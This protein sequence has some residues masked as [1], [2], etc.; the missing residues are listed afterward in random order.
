MGKYKDN[1]WLGLES[2]QEDQIIFGR[3]KEIEEMSQCILNYNETLLFGK[4]G[5]GKSSIINAGILPVARAHDYIP[6]VVRLDHSNKH[7][8][9]KQINDQICKYTTICNCSTGKDI[10]E[11]L[12][13]E[14]FHTREFKGTTNAKSKSKLLIVFDQFEEIFT[15][16]GNAATKIQFFKEIGDVLNDVMPKSLTEDYN[17][18]KKDNT[19][20]KTE[21]VVQVTGFA[22]MTDLFSCI[23]EQVKSE[24]NQYI[25]DNDIHF[26]FTLREDFLSEFEYYT[27]R[28][29]SLKQHRYGLRPINEEQAAEIIM[30]PRPELVDEGV[31]RLII[32]TVTNRTDF[33]LGDEPE[34]DV[35]AAVLSLFLS[36]IYD[37]REN[38]HDSITFE[39]VKTF[40]RNII[41]D[42]YEESIADLTPDQI[43]FLE[44]ELLTGE[45]RRD[46]LS[47]SDL[48][49]GGFSET[50]LRHLIDDKKILRLFS[51]GGD[52]RIEFIHD[53]LCPIIKERKEQRKKQLESE[54]ERIYYQK[55]I[56]RQ[57]YLYMSLLLILS[58]AIAYI[59]AITIKSVNRDVAVNVNIKESNNIK[60]DAYWRVG[61]IVV[62]NS[63]TLCNDTLDKVKNSSTFFVPRSKRYTDMEYIV[64]PIIGNIKASSSF[65][66]IAD[67]TNILIKVEPNTKE[68][69]LY[70]KLR[71]S[72]GSI[73]P[74]IGAIVIWGSQVTKTSK[75]GDFSFNEPSDYEYNKE[76]YRTIKFIKEGYKVTEIPVKK[77][78]SLYKFDLEDK[79]LFNARCVEFENIDTTQYQH[80]QIEGMYSMKE[81]PGKNLV[82]NT[83]FEN[84][85][86]IRGFYYY[87]DSYL[88]HANK[89]LIYIL[90]NGKI[91]DGNKLVLTSTDDAY[92]KRTIVAYL[93]EDYHIIKGEAF[94]SEKIYD[95]KIACKYNLKRKAE[96]VLKRVH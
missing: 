57:K 36:Q 59:I 71:V 13:W 86:T 16:Q 48:K 46:S 79:S 43:D 27:T 72:T 51:Y 30:K 14:Y 34:I 26:V 93:T 10:D 29:P 87:K 9:I 23:A 95:F 64:K 22:N 53:I 12:L 56:K 94:T 39:L 73:Q 65:F 89:R 68:Q 45:N 41:K 17:S 37:K 82:I 7:S 60:D 31:A 42:F 78:G 4:S 32:E 38:E 92:N 67:S 63:D 28:I 15:L 76:A 20:Q 81:G 96:D 44:E 5:I 24:G 54:K 1:P 3:N 47:R 66:S 33:T 2:Y 35:D 62:S 52:L 84:D 50:E 90:F 88:K 61:L 83:Y 55:K 19:S 18:E 8:Y 58:T 69:A 21:E 40:G 70:G 74:V 77:N 25:E 6:V 49:A 85:S 80:L 91:T 11:Q 75:F